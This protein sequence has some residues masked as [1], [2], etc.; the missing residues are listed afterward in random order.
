MYDKVKDLDMEMM[1]LDAGY[2]TPAIARELIKDGI[3]PLFPYKRPMT[4]DGFFKKYEYVYDEY[5][6]CY[7]CPADQSLTYQTTNQDGY[8]EYKSYKSICKNCPYLSKCTESKEHE[9]MIT[10]HIWEEDLEINEDIRHTLGNKEI[11]MLRKETIER[12]FGTAKEQHRFRYTQYIGNARMNMKARLT[13]ACMNLKKLA[14]ILDI[15]EGRTINQDSFLSFTKKYGNLYFGKKN[16]AGTRLQHQLC[17]QSTAVL[18]ITKPS[19]LIIGNS[20]F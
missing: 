5:Y 20:N 2:K 6:D 7:I 14:K 18:F 17:L 4:K 9:K 13:F 8:K 15:R 1:V 19:F 16:G 11:Y 10:R 3:Q 12:L